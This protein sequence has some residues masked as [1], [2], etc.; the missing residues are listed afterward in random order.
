[1]I[2]HLQSSVNKME[3]VTTSIQRSKE[4]EMEQLNMIN[5]LFKVKKY[6]YSII[7]KNIYSII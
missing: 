6:I 7:E 3:N 5:K 1:M 2:H 4:I